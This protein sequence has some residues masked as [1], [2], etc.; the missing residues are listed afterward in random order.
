MVLHKNKSSKAVVNHQ[1]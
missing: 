1:E